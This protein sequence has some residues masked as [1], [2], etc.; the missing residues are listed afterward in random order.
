MDQFALP[1]GPSRP[2][3][4]GWEPV[5]PG[6]SGQPSLKETFLTNSEGNFEESAYFAHQTLRN[7]IYCGYIVKCGVL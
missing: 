1:E 6:E 5:C 3:E 2:E 4:E 7:G